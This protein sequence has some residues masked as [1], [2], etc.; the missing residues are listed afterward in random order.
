MLGVED[1]VALLEVCFMMLGTEIVA[2]AG[3]GED[4]EDVNM[5]DEEDDTKFP[6]SRIWNPVV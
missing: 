6:G 1:D 5:R 4:V 3:V 2:I